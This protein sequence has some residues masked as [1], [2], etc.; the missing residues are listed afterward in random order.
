M[1]TNARA[2]RLILRL[3]PQGDG[4]IL[5]IPPGVAERDWR[6]F[7]DRNTDWLERALSRRPARQVIGAGSVLPIGGRDVTVIAEDTRRGPPRL[8][9]DSLILP[10][11]GP[12]GP[13]VAAFLKF[14]ARDVMEPATRLYARRVGR[15]VA[16]ITLRDNRS[17]WGSCSTTG[18]ISLS[19]RLAMAPDS[20]AVYVAAHEAAHLVE[21]NHS[22]RYWGL[23]GQIM[24]G[25]ETERDW[26]KRHGRAL[27]RYDFGL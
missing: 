1:Q 18:A 27:H 9:G 13:R 4:A 3:D 5:T 20:V 22:P 2:R 21:M 17:R 12:A 26:L 23:L 14:R 15:R 6:R 25:W 8:E 19:W 24:P 11:Q 7:L 16:S 10:G